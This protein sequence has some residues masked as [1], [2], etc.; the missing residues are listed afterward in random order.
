MKLEWDWIDDELG[1]VM[2]EKIDDESGNGINIE[3]MENY[4]YD[5]FEGAYLN[6]H[7]EELSRYQFS[8]LKHLTSLV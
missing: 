1:R 4:R 6:E 5:N 2:E 8:C 3:S 7:F